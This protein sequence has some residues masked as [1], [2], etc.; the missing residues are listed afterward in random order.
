MDTHK[1][2]DAKLEDVSAQL[3]ET[4]AK[5]RKLNGSPEEPLETGEDNLK[6]TRE[7]LAEIRR[8]DAMSEERAAMVGAPEA[9]S[10]KFDDEMVASEARHLRFRAR[11]AAYDA[12]WACHRAEHKMFMEKMDRI[13]GKSG[14]SEEEA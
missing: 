10:T 1:Q 14:F 12:S 5:L 8:R 6:R 2:R 9:R 3:K 7:I 4:L 11:C 13:F